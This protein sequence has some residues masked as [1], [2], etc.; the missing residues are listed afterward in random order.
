MTRYVKTF[1][2]RH[3]SCN[4]ILSTVSSCLK[5]VKMLTVLVSTISNT[6]LFMLK[7]LLVTFANAKATHILISKNMS[8]NAIFNDQRL[9]IR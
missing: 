5:V 9:T 4:K 3:T 7:K 6:Q 1:D 2:S 8:V